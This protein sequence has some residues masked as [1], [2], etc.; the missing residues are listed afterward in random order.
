MN[1]YEL[2]R[3][4][5]D[6]CFD[7]P[8]KIKPNHIALYFFTIEHCNRLGW[9]EKFGLPTE[10]AKSAIGI[11]SYNT[12]IKTLNELVE[13]GFI[14]MIVKSKNQYSSNIVAL[15]NFNKATNKAL[16]KA[17]IKHSI[18]HDTKQGE[19]TVQSIDSIDKQETIKPLNQ[20]QEQIDDLP[21]TPVDD[22]VL[23][24]FD[25]FKNWI[26]RNATNVEK[27]KEPINEE[28]FIKLKQYDAI[29]VK[30]ILQDMHNKKDLLKKYNSAYLTCLNWIKLRNQ[31][32]NG[33][34]TTSIIDRNREVAKQVI[35]ELNGG[36][37]L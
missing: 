34:K 28:Q 26:S 17:I 8:E 30:E 33:T 21:I 5:F 4:F 9:K 36:A 14:K 27:L 16:D 6:Y 12:Y 24:E 15:S 7:N 29:V 20:E 25:K 18:K 10:M 11:H 1:S 22:I 23:S 19:S 13:W 31:K 32:N 2:S 37:D 35:R 3:N